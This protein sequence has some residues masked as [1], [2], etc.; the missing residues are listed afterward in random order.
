MHGEQ[1]LS[2][3]ERDDFA[4]RR[5]GNDD[6]DRRSCGCGG[7]RG[8]GGF[9]RFAPDAR[10]LH[11][12]PGDQGEKADDDQ[13]THYD[14]GIFQIADLRLGPS[15]LYAFARL[16]RHARHAMNGTETTTTLSFGMKAPEVGMRLD[17][18]L[19][20]KAEGFSRSQLQE[21]VRQGRV[22]LDG[23]TVTD[24][25][26][27]VKSIQ[28]IE[29]RVPPPHPPEPKGEAIGLK[30]LHEDASLIVIDKPAGLVVH[31]APG[32]RTGTLVNALIHHCGESLSGVGGVARPGIVHRLDKDTS[33]VMVVAKTDR[34]HR[35]LSAQFADHGRT[36]ALE[37]RYLAIVWG[38]PVPFKGMIRAR[39]ARHPANRLKMAVSATKGREAITHYEVIESFA[40]A[41]AH[42]AISLVECRLE[43]GRTH[44]VRVHL[45]H[46]GH[47][48]IGDDLYGAGFRSRTRVLRE[49]LQTAILRLERQAL[50]AGFL[51]FEHPE[52]GKTMQFTADLPA[53]MKQILEELR[54]SS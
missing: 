54:T 10:G 33:G 1:A 36:T 9:A 15:A 41:G 30:V 16:G 3:R 38:R 28:T 39:L 46:V 25:G 53:D 35:A 23:A 45:A 31:P 29:I 21:L 32:N 7:R 19:A 13:H 43:T 40:G 24:P 20:L 18:L 37:R 5:G 8:T 49:S 4:S 27:R 47:P 42:A 17:R 6:L 34:A 44:Q 2:D 50:H 14:H 22:R 11:V 52:T 51:A 12:K 26:I 48:V